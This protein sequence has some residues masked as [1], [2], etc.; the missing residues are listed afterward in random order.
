MNFDELAFDGLEQF[1]PDS[2]H[3]DLHEEATEERERKNKLDSSESEYSDQEYR[4]MFDYRL[5]VDFSTGELLNLSGEPSEPAYDTVKYKHPEHFTK[6]DEERLQLTSIAPQSFTSVDQLNEF[7]SGVDRRRLV[8]YDATKALFYQ[9]SGEARLNRKRQKFKKSQYR[10]LN[11]LTHNLQYRN[12]IIGTRE[13]VAKMLGVSKQNLTRTLDNLGGLV[14]VY[15][16]KDSMRRSEIKILVSPAYGFKHV[17]PK[18]DWCNVNSLRKNATNT[19][20]RPQGDIETILTQNT[21]HKDFVTKDFEENLDLYSWG[22]SQSLS[23]TDKE[24][25]EAQIKW[26]EEQK[27]FLKQQKEIWVDT[28]NNWFKEDKAA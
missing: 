26:I 17:T 9:D 20:C 10:L 8:K 3:E 5:S 2:I 21:H 15:T 11:K 28:L 23:L 27:K 19:W 25:E 24:R 18:H 12:I 6:D 7:M 13:D 16:E 14:R 22:V 1:I 4:A